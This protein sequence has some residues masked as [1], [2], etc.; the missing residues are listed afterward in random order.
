MEKHSEPRRHALICGV[1]LCGKTTLAH[2]MAA[3]E[4][5]QK[6]DR[7]PIIVYDPVGTHTAAG[8]WPDGTFYFDDREK[9]LKYI[10]N[11]KTEA[12]IFVD[13]SDDIFSH[14]QPEN[15]MIIRRG[16]HY[17]WQCILIT[18]RPHLISPSAR[19]QCGVCFMF[20][21]GVS[22]AQAMGKEFG[23]NDIHK[24]NLDT[25][26][27]LVLRSGT[28][29]LERGNVFTHSKG[30]LAWTD[31]DTTSKSRRRSSS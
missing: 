19:T 5:K 30:A 14:S 22:D 18:Q 12:I 3:E 2:L 13:E 6:K 4:A 16:R 23:H 8:T 21:L 15:T 7:R 31:S 28:S 17:G 1:T 27:F 9:F 24:I 29:K 25:G 10:A 26:D 11:L 20:R